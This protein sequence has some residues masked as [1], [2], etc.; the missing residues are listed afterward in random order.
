MLAA[1]AEGPVDAVVAG[2]EGLELGVT[3]CADW[4]AA[5]EVCAGDVVA[6]TEEAAETEEAETV[7]A[8]DTE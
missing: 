5:A 8:D 4:V 1:G 3:E 7:L 2:V 6:A